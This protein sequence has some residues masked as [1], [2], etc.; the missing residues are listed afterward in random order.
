MLRRS[1]EVRGQPPQ[2]E[3]DNRKLE[4]DF[5][6]SVQR[7]KQ[8]APATQG[9]PRPRRTVQVKSGDTFSGIAAARHLPK[10]AL[11]R[12]NP[13]FDPRR[14]DGILN[15]DRG[16]DGGWDPDY[17]RP[18]DRLRVPTQP[19][20]APAQ[21][22][23]PPSAAR[24]TPSGTPVPPPATATPVAAGPQHASDTAPLSLAFGRLVPVRAGAGVEYGW[25]LSSAEPATFS[26][27]AKASWAIDDRPGGELNVNVKYKSSPAKD[28]P[29]RLRT[30]DV[31]LVFGRKVE[32]GASVELRGGADRLSWYV[33]D[34]RKDLLVD[35]VKIKLG[36]LQPIAIA[37]A[38]GRGIVASVNQHQVSPRT[39]ERWMPL[40]DE[41]WKAVKSSE[42]QVSAEH[43]LHPTTQTGVLGNIAP[44]ATLNDLHS[45]LRA[46]QIPAPGLAGLAA[47]TAGT[48]AAFAGSKA[49]DL[50][51]GDDIRHPIARKAVDGLGAGLVGVAASTATQ[52]AWPALATRAA[53]LA[54]KLPPPSDKAAAV[55]R[56]AK[57]AVG[58][59]APLLGK[60]APV[61][62]TATR[63]VGKLAQSGAGKAVGK[64]ARVGGP[65][66]ALIAGVPD[67]VSAYKSFR[68]GDH[69]NGWKSVAKAG[70]RIGCTAAGA[71]ALSFIPVVGT[72]AGAVA[73]GIVGDV[74]AGLF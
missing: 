15:Y 6:G 11:Y 39:A 29:G 71:A 4:A 57:E 44:K 49:T 67:A 58:K 72:V 27:Y 69:A 45:G 34:K 22:A 31:G 32:I 46:P 61:T 59:V 3:R 66:G 41:V 28:A 64:L 55:I 68:G 23:T 50:L 38:L 40:R 54:G 2:F 30:V 20:Q 63:I 17:L 24:A 48:A 12:A 56:Q 70:V 52:K 43:A 36:K 19:R 1:E 37:G 42:I 5:Q 25:K 35:S 13:Q 18:G 53:S 8:H 62:N 10:R 51:I 14:E 33:S 7:A 74:L 47:W 60:A 26:P 21:N 16:A 73:G 65:A 9:P